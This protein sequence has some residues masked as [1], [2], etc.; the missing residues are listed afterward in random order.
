MR[1]L[2][3]GRFCDHLPGGIQSHVASLLASLAED[4]EFVNLVPSR[5]GRSA[6]FL[7]GG[8]PVIRTAG[9]NLD[10]SL[11]LS[12]GLVQVAWREHRQ[13][14]FD[15]IHLNFPDP[16]S[17]LASL[18]LPA[19]VPRVITWHADIVR[20]RRLLK[21]YRPWERRILRQAAA[22]VTATPEHLRDSPILNVP[23][24]REKIEVIPFGFDLMRFVQ[25]HPETEALKARYPG[26]RIFALG[27]HVAYKGFD[28]L[29]KAMPAVLDTHDDTHLILGGSGP[30][31]G[32]LAELT[33][34]M[35]LAGRVHAIGQIPDASLPA[36]Y[37]CCDLFCLPSISSAEAFGI[38]QVEA[39]AAGKPIVNTAL[40]N[41]VNFVAPKG[42]A[43]LTV[44]PGDPDA[45][46]W[47]ILA[48]L[49]DAVLR[50]KLG[51]NGR[52]RAEQEFSL[53]AMRARMLAL[54]HRL[55]EP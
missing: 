14:P 50:R 29:L 17:H 48:L 19:S 13:K 34:E 44:A 7:L 10:G 38:V 35:G 8:V 46:S 32:E 33:R 28:V 36:Y 49:Q 25:P 31:S 41:G 43:A 2:C 52:L 51:E 40:K 23:G 55:A 39:M 22:I 11:S 3:F 1:V 5:D 18:I 21:L 6:R 12:P 30:L 37:Q 20:R 9:W 45:L 53:A 47:E 16:M 27:R 26:R 24:I 54:Y 15:L 42:V 4:V